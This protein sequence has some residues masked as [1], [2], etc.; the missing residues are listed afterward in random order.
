MAS[1]PHSDF[2]THNCTLPTLSNLPI[3]ATLTVFPNRVQ[4]VRCKGKDM[5]CQPSR[6]LPTHCRACITADEDCIFLQPTPIIEAG[7]A[8]T[9]VDAEEAGTADAMGSTSKA[10]AVPTA[11]ALEAMEGVQAMY[12]AEG[13]IVKLTPVLE[14]KAKED[15]AEG[16]L[17]QRKQFEHELREGTTDYTSLAAEEAVA[18]ALGEDLDMQEAPESSTVASGTAGASGMEPETVPRQG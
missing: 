3:F 18:R 13:S 5:Y 15:H 8:D 10:V 16:V 6:L 12:K 11:E 2:T 7:E 14:E 9:D 4:C 17:R 1:N